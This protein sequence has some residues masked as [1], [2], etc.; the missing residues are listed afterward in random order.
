MVHGNGCHDVLVDRVFT[1]DP[2][3]ADERSHDEVSPAGVVVGR[4]MKFGIVHARCIDPA[5]GKV[6]E[7]ALISKRRFTDGPDLQLR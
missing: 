2:R 7:A 5:A 3:S 6:G 1:H 4:L